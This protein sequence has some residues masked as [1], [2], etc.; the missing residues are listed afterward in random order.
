MF[1]DRA[2]A[3]RRLA[4]ELTGRH[5]QDPVVLALPRGGVPVAFEIARRLQAPLDLVLAR[6]I[7]V[8]GQPELAVGAVVDGDHPEIVINVGV[9]SGS[10]LDTED[11]E[12]MAHAEL[13]EIRRRRELYM[14]GRPCVPVAGRTAILV[15]DGVAT[16]ATV[17]AGLHAVARRKP[18]RVV[19]A[20]PVAPPE[21]LQ[22]LEQEADEVVCLE[23]PRWFQ[24]V[25]ENYADFHQVSDAEVTSILAVD[26]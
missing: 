4:D 13:P 6:K 3:G 19:L 5:Y 1:R 18:L 2:D 22:A 12:R 16:G 9:L 8:P 17:R 7:G 26:V 21:T 23:S 14:R 10:G 11:I 24:S 25:G 15:D 20:V